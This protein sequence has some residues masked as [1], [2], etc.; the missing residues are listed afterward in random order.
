[1]CLNLS[2]KTEFFVLNTMG[3]KLGYGSEKGQL[4]SPLRYLIEVFTHLKQ[5]LGMTSIFVFTS[6]LK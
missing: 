4:L 6:V 1:M 2:P 5:P 3:Y